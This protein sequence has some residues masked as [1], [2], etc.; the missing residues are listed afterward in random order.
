MSFSEIA[1]IAMIVAGVAAFG[2]TLK[3][4]KRPLRRVPTRL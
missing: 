2:A 3:W 4:L 1:V